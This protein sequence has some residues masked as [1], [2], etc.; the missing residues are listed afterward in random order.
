MRNPTARRAPAARHRRT[1]ALQLGRLLAVLALLLLSQHQSA[2]EEPPAGGKSGVLYGYLKSANPRQ[3]KIVVTLPAPFDDVE[4]RVADP[5][6][7]DLLTRA[8]PGDVL[9]FTTDDRTNPTQVKSLEEVRR[10]V[11]RWPRIIVLI[12]ALAVVALLAAA[13]LWRA[14][15]AFLI[16]GDNRYSNSQTQLALWFWALASVYLS[17][18]VLR[19]LYLGFDYVGGIEIPTNL[20]ALTGLSAFSFGGAK[21]ITTQ[22]I[23]RAAQAPAA[24]TPVGKFPAAQPHLLLDLVQNDN[25]EADLGDFEMIL[26]A[27]AAIAIF[28]LASFH[29]LGALQLAQHVTLPDVDSTLLAAFG[30]GHGAYL[31]KKAASNL[32]EG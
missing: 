23:A 30:I 5:A 31:V 12:I 3:G 4:L 2:A 15:T 6:A 7:S 32:G 26:I 17:A 1:F 9:R 13:F 10:L 20:L 25:R 18:L 29:F 22:K 16:G 24:P 28:G 8:R 19:V 14:P 11:G 21:V 27:L